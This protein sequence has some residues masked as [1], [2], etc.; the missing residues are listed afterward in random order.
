MDGVV[1][2][3]LKLYA[4]DTI[5]NILQ[6]DSYKMFQ[7]IIFFWCQKIFWKKFFFTKCCLGSIE[8]LH[9]DWTKLF[10]VQMFQFLHQNI[11]LFFLHI[12]LF[13]DVKNMTEPFTESLSQKVL[14]LKIAKK[15]EKYFKVYETAKKRKWKKGSNPF[16]S[17]N[18][19]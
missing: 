9:K 16:C 1:C 12:C 2:R 13:Q 4:P 7:V 19:G 17:G 10:R 6:F 5:R 18:W 8:V 11:F 3:K 15:S 14:Q